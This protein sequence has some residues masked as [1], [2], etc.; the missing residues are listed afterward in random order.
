MA[1]N[2]IFGSRIILPRNFLFLAMMLLLIPGLSGC[3]HL[4]PSPVAQEVAYQS[5]ESREHVY[6]I[7][8]ESPV[9]VGK[10]GGLP[11]LTEYFQEC[12]IR[13]TYYFN[14]YKEGINGK[15]L[16]E[17]V[18]QIHCDPKARV[19]LV[20]WSYGSMISLKAIHNL[21]ETGNSIDTMVYLDSFSLRLA[22]G[23]SQP[24]NV[25]KTVLI[26]RSHINPPKGF[27][28]PDTHYIDV[29]SH[30]N[31]PM[32]PHTVDVLLSEAACLASS[33][34]GSGVAQVPPEPDIEP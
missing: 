34:S 3:A 32:A 18:R 33:V 1:N 6:V 14:P 4:C 16:A 11:E 5:E 12:G 10:W 27:A 30:L 28:C 31:L 17:F 15:N 2:I 9:D 25:G 13:H 21:A 26:Y 19:M 23:E 29:L 8:V 24:D 7:F 20:G 22:G